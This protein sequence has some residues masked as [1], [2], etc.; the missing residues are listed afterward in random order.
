VR[1]RD[2]VGRE[3]GFGHGCLSMQIPS[4]LP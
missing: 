2:E 1:R 3:V 4:R